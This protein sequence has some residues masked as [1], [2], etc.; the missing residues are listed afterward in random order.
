MTFKEFIGNAFNW[1]K[2]AIRAVWHMF[3]VLVKRVFK[4]L[5]AFM[6]AIGDFIGNLR[7]DIEAGFKKIFVVKTY[8]RD[9]VDIIKDAYNGGKV[10]TIPTTP[11]ELFGDNTEKTNYDYNIVITDND[12]DPVKIET[13]SAEELDKKIG[14]R[15]SEEVSEIKY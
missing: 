6:R 13:I 15:F 3:K 4:L 8:K 5:G 10:K 9:L 12:F 1:I 2:K 14:E 11:D 7:S